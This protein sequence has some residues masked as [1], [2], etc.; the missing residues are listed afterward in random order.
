MLCGGRPDTVALRPEHGIARERGGTSKA[1]IT[2]AHRAVVIINS[3]GQSDRRGNI[4][5]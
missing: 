5:R 2:R 3:P 4:C 1:A